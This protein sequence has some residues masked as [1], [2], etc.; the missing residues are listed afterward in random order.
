METIYPQGDELFVGSQESVRV[1]DI[2]EPSAPSFKSSF[3]HRRSCDPVLP[4]GDVAYVT[5]RSNN[6]NCPGDNN[7]L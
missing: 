5:L 6:S 3:N 2:A 1:F 4:D 7:A